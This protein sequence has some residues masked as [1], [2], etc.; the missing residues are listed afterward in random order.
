M[1]SMY[2]FVLDKYL[3]TLFIFSIFDSKQ[4]ISINFREM[5]KNHL[6]FVTCRHDDVFYIKV[7]III[8]MYTN[9]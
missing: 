9:C 1:I 6:E 5:F 2:L 3:D 4:Q 8:I 7:Y